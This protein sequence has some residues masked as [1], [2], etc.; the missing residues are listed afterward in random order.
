MSEINAWAP[1]AADNTAAP[2][3]GAPE[4]T[5]KVKDVND[6]LREM[7][8]AARRLHDDLTLVAGT[9][10]GGVLT[11][12]GARTIAAY[13][14]GLS[15]IVAPDQA[16][17]GAITARYKALAAK[18]VKKNGAALAAGD[19]VAGVPVKLVFNADAWHL[20]SCAGTVVHQ[21]TL[22]ATATALRAECRIPIGGTLL[23]AVGTSPAT[24]LG[25]G[26]WVQEP[27]GAIYSDGSAVDADGAS[28]ALTLGGT[29][30][31]NF[32]N[33]ALFPNAVPAHAHPVAAHDHDISHGH[34]QS[35]HYHDTEKHGHTMSH[36]HRLPDAAMIEVP[37]GTANS[38][39]LKI[40]TDNN[41]T[42]TIMRSGL[43]PG[44]AWTFDATP[45]I[46]GNASAYTTS[47]NANIQ[48]AN[49]ASGGRAL[50]TQA[51]QPSGT[52]QS[53][54]HGKIYRLWRRTA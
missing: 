40:T 37:F 10:S 26:T 8:A 36:A 11:I 51:N 21:S 52:I 35:G 48:A 2:P 50:T 12:A 16:N 47:D 34:G 33:P 15:V 24:L 9:L 53:N 44:Y 30:G 43:W 31:R 39:R 42:I 23:C 7:M 22:D 3:D 18:A 6:T 45:A 14:N 46:T 27:A 4:T 28:L 20:L 25:Y 49:Q 13:F 5:T 41:N 1:L 32:L 38:A 29:T 54:A 17:V 19:L